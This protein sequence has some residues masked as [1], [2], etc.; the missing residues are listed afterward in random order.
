MRATASVADSGGMTSRP[1]IEVDASIPAE[2]GPR[3]LRTGAV[4]VLAITLL[5][6]FLVVSVSYG[7]GR[8]YGDTSAADAV[9]AGRA[10]RDWAFGVIL[11][12]GLGAVVV[13]T[14]RGSRGRRALTLAAALAVV[15]TLV[16]VPV[17]AVIG[18]HQKF[19]GFPR[20]PSCT[21]GSSGGPAGP[22]VRAAQDAFEEIDHPGPFSGGGEAGMDGCASQLMLDDE[23]DVPTAYRGALRA[24]GWRPG[25]LEPGLVEATKGDQRFE[26]S[27]DRHGAWWVRIGPVDP[28]R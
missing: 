2:P 7:M 17:S 13:V 10:L 26:A 14:A 3:R 20:V 5:S 25:R 16:G 24:A 28:V 8:E 21:D 19:A 27:L 18:V 15:V 9:V 23:V 22:V 1:R 4:I 11:V 12:A 6:A